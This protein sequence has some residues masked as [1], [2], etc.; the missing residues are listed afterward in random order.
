MF[1]K[2]LRLLKNPVSEV[3]EEIAVCEFDC[4]ETECRSGDWQSCERRLQGNR[5]Q[6]PEQD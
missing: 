5:A 3:P 6:A 2:L 4:S 1:D